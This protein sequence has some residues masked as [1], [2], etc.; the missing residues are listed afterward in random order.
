LRW[1]SRL[2]WQVTIIMCVHGGV[3]VLEL[4]FALAEQTGLAGDDHYVCSWWGLRVGAGVCAG[5]A[6][7]IGR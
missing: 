4:V 1:Q 5:R 3:C 2:D 6:D 7:W